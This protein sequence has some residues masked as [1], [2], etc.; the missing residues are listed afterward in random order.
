MEIIWRYFRL[1]LL[2]AGSVFINT[3][4]F[5]AASNLPSNSTFCPA[6]P[7]LTALTSDPNY[8][9]PSSHL[10]LTSSLDPTVEYLCSS[11]TGYDHNGIVC[12]SLKCPAP[13]A[14][15]SYNQRGQYGDP[16]YRGQ[17]GPRGPY[18]QSSGPYDVKESISVGVQVASIET[19]Y[20][21]WKLRQL[22]LNA[23][24]YIVCFVKNYPSIIY[25]VI[26]KDNYKM[27]LTQSEVIPNTGLSG[28]ARV[29]F[30]TEHQFSCMVAAFS[31]YI[32]EE[33]AD[34]IRDPA[35]SL[36]P[37][38]H[39]CPNNYKWYFC[40]NLPLQYAVD[41]E[42]LSTGKNV[43]IFAVQRIG[44]SNTSAAPATS[45]ILHYSLKVDVD[46]YVCSS[47]APDYTTAVGCPVQSATLNIVYP[48][49]GVT[50]C[51]IVSLDNVTMLCCAVNTLYC[52][53]LPEPADGVPEY[54]SFCTLIDITTNKLCTEKTVFLAGSTKASEVQYARANTE[55]CQFL[56]VSSP[57]GPLRAY[58]LS[59]IVAAINNMTQSGDNCANNPPVSVSTVSLGTESVFH[60]AVSCSYKAKCC[61]LPQTCVTCTR[62]SKYGDKYLAELLCKHSRVESSQSD[63]DMAYSGP[64][65]IPMNPYGLQSN[66]Y[67]RP[68]N[69]TNPY[70]RPQNYTNQMA[71]PY[72]PQLPPA[73]PYFPQPGPYFPQPGP[74]PPPKQ[75]PIYGVRMN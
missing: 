9:S 68:Q 4:E 33:R 66:L 31:S 47:K 58:C 50:Q 10:L 20:P 74:Y 6:I 5:A 39:I 37:I 71:A 34:S 38:Y 28:L 51:T 64:G 14:Y 32:H 21:C 70:G 43:E 16:A 41:V 25:Q 8:Q 60:S 63:D 13:N 48:L 44:H 62:P 12:Y 1:L 23:Y 56:I 67:G 19:A 2:L 27:E 30:T 35:D 65:L 36:T 7:S 54:G 29:T 18:G 15:G 69:Y 46:S 3:T 49:C 24:V 72:G 26:F 59:S 75:V 11:G 61:G 55:I 73:G 17:M 57:S 53:T 45:A 52:S 40:G 42:M 22:R